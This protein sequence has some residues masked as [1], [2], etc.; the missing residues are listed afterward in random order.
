M[1]NGAQGDY[2]R[3]TRI[4]IDIQALTAVGRI[5]LFKDKATSD[6]GKPPLGMEKAF[7]FS[8]T[9]SELTGASNIISFIYNKIIAKA[10]TM[11]TKD[12]MG[13]NLATPVAVDSD[14]AFGSVV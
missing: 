2:W 10:E 6:A 12:I 1:D 8:F 13:N 3:I 5:A 14:I 11:I 9:L 7:Q 4:V